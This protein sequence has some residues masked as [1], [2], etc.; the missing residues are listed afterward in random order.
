MTQTATPTAR[1]SGREVTKMEKPEDV[2]AM[3]RL[4]AAGWGKKRIAAELGCS[5][6]TV[7]RYLENGGWK[8]YVLCPPRPG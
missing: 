4:H 2:A 7:K 6:N 3:L 8:P 1:T 5:K